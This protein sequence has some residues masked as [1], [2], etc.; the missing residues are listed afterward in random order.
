MAAI[1]AYVDFKYFGKLPRAGGTFD[2]PADLMDELRDV[3]SIVHAA[4]R[5]EHDK[6]KREAERRAKR[7]RRG[8]RG[9]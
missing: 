6:A 5:R 1:Q 4:E 3:A 7:G 9:R 2:Q 8:S